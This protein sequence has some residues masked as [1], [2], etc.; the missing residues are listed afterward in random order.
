MVAKLHGAY[1]FVVTVIKLWNEHFLIAF[2]Y[3]E[4][5]TMPSG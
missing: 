1:V 2:D 3:L 4:F 5:T